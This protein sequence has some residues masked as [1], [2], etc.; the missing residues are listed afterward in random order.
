MNA[1]RPSESAQMRLTLLARIQSRQR[2]MLLTIAIFLVVGIAILLVVHGRGNDR[3]APG[4]VDRSDRVADASAG[5][6][7]SLAALPALPEDLA[8]AAETAA[9]QDAALSR[10]AALKANGAT[11]FFRGKLSA[12]PRFVFRGGAAD[13]DRALDC[14]AA[15]QLYEAGGDADGQRAVAQVVLNRVRHPA[16]PSSICGVVFQGAERKSGCQFTFTCD[17]SLARRYSDAA[18][19]SARRIA[20]SMMDGATFTKVGSATHYHTDWVHPYW[21]PSLVKLASVDSH[22]FF[23]WPG[24]WGSNSVLRKPVTGHEPAVAWLAFRPSHADA[25]PLGGAGL[26][27]IANMAVAAGDVAPEAVGLNAAQLGGNRIRLVHPQGGA[28]LIQLKPGQ[29]ANNMTT[30]ALRLCKDQSMCHV[31]AWFDARSVPKGFPVGPQQRAKLTFD[32][33]RDRQTGTE[34]VKFDCNLFKRPA[35]EQCL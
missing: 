1:V 26:G 33:L 8:K 10:D 9:E 28:Y 32:Y 29:A 15:A 6:Q 22:L 18:W 25:E 14:L 30:L 21:S 2:V 23:R 27:D 31:M 3:D 16:F 13:R 34:W 24:Y 20:A 4:G 19:S 17:G 5:P 12:A 11:P 35:A 7:R